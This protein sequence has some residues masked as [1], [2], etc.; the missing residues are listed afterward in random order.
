M[1]IKNKGSRAE[2]FHGNALMTTGGLTKK[3]LVMNKH[4]RIVSAKKVKQSK[5]P[6][7]NPLLKGNFLA[8]RK[9]SKKPSFWS[10][11]KIKK[12]KYS[13]NLKH[14]VYL[15]IYLLC[16]I[17]KYLILTYK[18]YTKHSKYNTHNLYQINISSNKSK[19]K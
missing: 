18:I 14:Q 3:D 6:E 17:F 11:S 5:D 12:F 2:V 19:L 13:K 4:G 16:L 9:S 15:K 1:Q 7:L 8:K 10:K